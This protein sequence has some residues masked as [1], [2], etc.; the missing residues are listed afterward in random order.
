MMTVQTPQQAT[1][2]ENM[3][4]GTYQYFTEAGVW[5]RR[6]DMARYGPAEQNNA[7]TYIE[8]SSR[9]DRVATDEIELFAAGKDEGAHF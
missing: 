4:A 8:S 5:L 1:V 3:N 2:A 9:T 6:Y 7:I